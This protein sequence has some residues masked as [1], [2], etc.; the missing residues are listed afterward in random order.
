MVNFVCGRDKTVVAI[1]HFNAW[2]LRIIHRNG[3]LFRVPY[4]RI[5]PGRDQVDRWLAEDQLDAVLWGRA[6]PDVITA[7]FIDEACEICMMASYV[8][9]VS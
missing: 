3:W 5:N 4:I 6:W 7:K 2:T 1:R 9:S 8:T